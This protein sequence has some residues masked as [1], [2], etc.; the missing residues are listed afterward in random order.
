MNGGE[1]KQR[2]P[3]Q[4]VVVLTG[5]G[6]RF[7]QF[8]T[9]R[10]LAEPD[11]VA[12]LLTSDPNRIPDQDLAP[13]S[14]YRVRL[15]DPRSV[16]EAF[17]QIYQD[18]EDI[19]V[20]I[21]NAAVLPVPGFKDFVANADEARVLESYA[22]NVA[23]ALFCIKHTL[24]RGRDRDKKIINILAGRALTGHKRHVEY[25]SSKAGLYNATLTLANDYPSH[26]FRNVMSGR[27]DQ[28]DKGDSPESMWAY[29]REFIR[30]PD[31]APYREI[32]FRPRLEFLWH[33]LRTYARHFRSCERR[34]VIRNR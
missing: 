24:G 11:L 2:V 26:A 14:V 4:Q 17:E 16:G 5:A 20:L 19:D 8:L 33:L 12:V 27:I 1:S 28:G 30:D 15:N 10:L 29:M 9:K 21:N 6:G 3:K 7:G 25:Y 18:H 32:H 13:H 31:P 23:G 34:D 22:V